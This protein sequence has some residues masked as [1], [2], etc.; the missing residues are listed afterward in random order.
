MIVVSARPLRDA[1]WYAF[2]GYG[3]PLAEEENMM[4]G[5]WMDL[6]ENTLQVW[7]CNGRTVIHRSTVA[8]MI[9]LEDSSPLLLEKKVV[10]QENGVRNLYN[11]IRRLPASSLVKIAPYG[12]IIHFDLPAGSSTFCR[13]RRTLEKDA[14][15][16][17]LAH[18]H[19]TAMVNAVEFRRILQNIRGLVAVQA[20]PPD[21]EPSRVFRG[22]AVG[23]ENG[24]DGR[25]VVFRGEVPV[26]STEAFPPFA[27][28]ASHLRQAL[29]GMRTAEIRIPE[30]GKAAPIIIQGGNRMGVVM[31]VKFEI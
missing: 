30:E 20:L 21:M 2:A 7:G 6:E 5:V 17:L 22:M 19:Q 27:V 18:N 10:L 26:F 3:K 23:W 25:R 1:L 15:D 28:Y 24:R 4:A 9:T 14:V 11:L 31:P 13:I 29:A 16:S 12:G 8:A